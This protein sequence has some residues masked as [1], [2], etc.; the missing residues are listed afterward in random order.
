MGGAIEVTNSPDLGS[1]FREALPVAITEESGVG[2]FSESG[3]FV[4]APDQPQCRIL[5]IEDDETNRLLLTRPLEGAGFQVPTADE[6]DNWNAPLF[7]VASSV[8]LLDLRLQ[9]VNGLETIE[10]PRLAR[11]RDMKFAALT[12]G[13]FHEQHEAFLA[14]GAD[15]F[16]RGPWPPKAGFECMERLLAEQ[17]VNSAPAAKSVTVSEPY[18]L[19]GIKRLP[20]DLKS[21]LPHAVLLLDTE[22]ILTTIHLISTIEPAL[23]GQLTRHAEAL[24][25]TAIMRAVQLASVV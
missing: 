23:V 24:E 18:D 10:N 15:D 2:D 16:V 11:G 25:F 9:G 13:V 7:R 19:T 8:R 20:D 22:R 5:L 3:S 4:V 17:C 12:T 14:A 1:T 6:T 21:T